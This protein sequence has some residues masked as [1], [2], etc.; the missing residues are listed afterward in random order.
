MRRWSLR[1]HPGKLDQIWIKGG[2]SGLTAPIE[3]QMARSGIE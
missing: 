2:G 1:E 3:L